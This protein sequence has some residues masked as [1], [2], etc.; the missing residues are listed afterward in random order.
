MLDVLRLG[1]GDS[2]TFAMEP[3]LTNVTANPELAVC[4]GLT[5]GATNGFSL[6]FIT[7]I[8]SAAVLFLILCLDLLLWLA[9][10]IGP[11]WW[12]K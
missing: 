12:L 6:I 10:R 2:D 9:V 1:R 11:L 4:V 3:G 5:T 8:S 7:S